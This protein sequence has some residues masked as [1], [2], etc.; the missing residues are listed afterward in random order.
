[1]FTMK[2]SGPRQYGPSERRLK[3]GEVRRWERGAH[4]ELALSLTYVL[5]VELGVVIGKSGRD[6]PAAQAM[7]H[8]AGYGECGV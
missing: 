6:I 7:S 5:I 2:V 8:V 1:M 3:S 4:M